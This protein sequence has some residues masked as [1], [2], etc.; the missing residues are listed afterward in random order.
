[1]QDNEDNVLS[2]CT[3]I[4]EGWARWLHTRLNTMSPKSPTLA[5]KELTRSSVAQCVTLDGVPSLLEIDQAKGLDVL[6]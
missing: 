1:M 3:L 2:D 5:R 6:L 4:R